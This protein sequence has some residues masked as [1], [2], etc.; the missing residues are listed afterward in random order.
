M[1]MTSPSLVSDGFIRGVEDIIEP[2]TT[3]VGKKQMEQIVMSAA[4]FPSIN[5]CLWGGDSI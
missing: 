5:F 3:M 4:S 2:T 1:D